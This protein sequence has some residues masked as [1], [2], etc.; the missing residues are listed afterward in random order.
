MCVCSVGLHKCLS[1]TVGMFSRSQG[2][3][4]KVSC[5][6]LMFHREQ[7]KG[8]ESWAHIKRERDSSTRIAPEP[9]SLSLHD[10]W[11]SLELPVAII[12]VY[13]HLSAAGGFISPIV[14]RIHICCT[15]NTEEGRQTLAFNSIIIII[16][17]IPFFFSIFLLILLQFFPLL[18]FSGE[19]IILC[20]YKC[21][22]FRVCVCC[23]TLCTSVE[24]ERETA[25]K[26]HY[27]T[28]GVYCW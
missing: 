11:K 20:L 27:I 28:I 14:S 6:G 4:K 5:C 12:K 19:G 3:K 25:W 7:E 23:R 26:Q 1:Y 8:E 17:F 9:P 15:Y 16:F 18:F 10:P 13:T 22:D 21:M 24:R 2:E